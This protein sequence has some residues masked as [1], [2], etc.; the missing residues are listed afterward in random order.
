[1]RPLPLLTTGLLAALFLPAAPATAAGETCQGQ[2]ATLVGA[3]LQTGLVGTEGPDVVV[4]NGA[5]SLDTL[6]G[7][8]LVCITDVTSPG[9][10]QLRTGT[11]NDV[12]DASLSGSSVDAELGAGAD[13]Y[14]ASAGRDTVL[15]GSS[16]GDGETDTDA[17]TVIAT[18]GARAGQSGDEVDSGMRGVP[19]PDVIQLAGVGHVLYWSGPQAPGSRVVV[20]SSATLRP[21]LG[22]GDVVIDAA[23]GSWT[24]DGAPVL[25]WAG[26]VSRFELSS[27]KAPHSL[28]FTGSDRDEYV[29]S[30]FPDGITAPQRFD[31]RG[32]DDTLLTPQG[33]IGGDG[34]SF[35]GGAGDDAIDLWAGNRLDLDLAAKRMTYRLG[36]T[37]ARAAFKSF[38]STRV[39][40]KKL[41]VRGTQR[42]DDVR[43]FACRATVRGRGGKDTLESYRTGEDS[44]E[45]KCDAR[46]SKIKVYG[47]RGNDTIKGSR[48]KDLLVGGKGR[49]TIDGNANRDRCSGEKLKSC[50]VTLR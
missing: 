19:N 42:A 2:P 32:G 31:L 3:P 44:Y 40:A 34:S 18:T 22:T 16:D 20:G 28:A 50:E 12:V 37:S 27:Q 1:M 13:H 39:G 7:D 43:F 24:E 23:A 49:D 15:T 9:V 26:E 45:L 21:T 30:Y 33:G 25:A 6:G 11:G 48:G 41:D 5:Q 46:K 14:T 47:N 29:Y 17:D 36:G 10:V 38:E 8:D 35:D 4:T